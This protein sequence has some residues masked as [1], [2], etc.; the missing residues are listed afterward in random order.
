METLTFSLYCR[1]A[2]TRQGRKYTSV[3]EWQAWRG[4][5][6]KRTSHSYEQRVGQTSLALQP[7]WKRVITALELRWGHK[8]T[9]RP[10]HITRAHPSL[11]KQLKMQPEIPCLPSAAG[12]LGRHPSFKHYQLVL[13]LERAVASAC[14]QQRFVCSCPTGSA[15]KTGSA[16]S[17]QGGWPPSYLLLSS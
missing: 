4:K 2:N 10:K 13:S 16:L 17:L 9:P 14:L 6:K 8:L 15:C 5:K 7:W 3:L 11:E 1:K 12:P